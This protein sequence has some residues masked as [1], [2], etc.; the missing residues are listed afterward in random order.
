LVYLERVSSRTFN[1]IIIK[2]NKLNK[3]TI[4]IIILLKSKGIINNLEEKEKGKNIIIKIKIKNIL[5]NK[6]S[7]YN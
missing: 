1:I 5:F 4:K 6:F 2:C 7:T 3:K